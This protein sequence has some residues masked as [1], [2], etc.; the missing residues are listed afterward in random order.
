[1]AYSC[2]VPIGHTTAPID[3]YLY[4]VGNGQKIIA[5]IKSFLDGTP[6]T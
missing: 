2:Q 6:D 1:M 4:N 5:I 3:S